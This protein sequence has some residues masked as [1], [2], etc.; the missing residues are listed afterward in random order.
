MKTFMQ[1]IMKTKKK[2]WPLSLLVAGAGIV[3]A[4]LTA[5]DKKGNNPNNT[6]DEKGYVTGTV[7]DTKGQPIQG[8]EIVID[9]TLIYNSNL[10][11]NSDANGKYKVKL[12][13]AFTWVATA[14]MNKNYNG[15]TYKYDLH[16]EKD[17]AF[18]SDGGVRNFNW[19]ISGAKPGSTGYYGAMIQLQSA[20]GSAIMAEDVD[21]ILTP[22]GP[23][24][25]GSTGQ[26]LTL[27]S[28]APRTEN[29]YKLA[30]IPLGRYTM[31][32][33]YSGQYLKLL[34]TITNEKGTELVINFEPQAPGGYCRN[35]TIIEYE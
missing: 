12:S 11:T 1:Q 24:I 20:F 23:L 8:A 17:E 6:G 3:M 28:G 14:T 22:S 33:K 34:N 19:K 26:P 2:L 15:K 7:T 21:F 29:Y 31:K 10:L 27:K 25:D 13:G 5:C 16:P 4:S 18:T 35:C 30:D 9:N 32:A